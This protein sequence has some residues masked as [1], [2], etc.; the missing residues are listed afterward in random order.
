M[1]HLVCRLCL[2]LATDLNPLYILPLRVELIS[3]CL[4]LQFILHP[5]LLWLL[6]A[7]I[8][9][10]LDFSTENIAKLVNSNAR[11]WH[12]GGHLAC[13]LGCS[14]EG[15]LPLLLVWNGD[16]VLDFASSKLII[17]LIFIALSRWVRISHLLLL[18]MLLEKYLV[19]LV[20]F[21]LFIGWSLMICL[22][23]W[24]PN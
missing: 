1:V 18:T 19:G 8:P 17:R 23:R 22:D 13:H 21:F 6:N 4:Q 2:R 12:L 14:I 3:Y 16:C 20:V 5:H 10:P 9:D 24:C 15:A 7:L 11:K